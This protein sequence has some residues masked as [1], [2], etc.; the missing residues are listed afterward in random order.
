MYPQHTDHELQYSSILRAHGF[1][2][3]WR[4]LLRQSSQFSPVAP[5]LLSQL[6]HL[7]CQSGQPCHV[8]LS[9]LLQ[10]SHL[11]PHG[12]QLSPV[13][14]SVLPQLGELCADGRR[15][16]LDPGVLGWLLADQLSQL[17]ELSLQLCE[18]NLQVSDGAVQLGVWA[19]LSPQGQQGSQKWGWCLS[20]A[21]CSIQP[22]YPGGSFL[23][24]SSTHN[25]TQPAAT[26]GQRRQ[27]DMELQEVNLAVPAE[28][29]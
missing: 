18:F 12:G 27:E 2:I 15:V 26:R 14:V 8:T 20:L 4:T 3:T 24:S 25:Y 10:L 21:G 19:G 17:Y 28:E 6:P 9:V 5:S 22:Q 1:I 11:S 7:L 16:L 23:L 29:E 13:A